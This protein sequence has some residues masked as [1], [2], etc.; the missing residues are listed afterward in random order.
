MNEGVNCHQKRRPLFV[1]PQAA[2]DIAQYQEA[3]VFGPTIGGSDQFCSNLTLTKRPSAHMSSFQTLADKN[4]NKIDKR[5]GQEEDPSEQLVRLTCN[6]RLINGQT[7]NDS[8]ISLPTFQSIEA[9]LQGCHISIMNI[10]NM[11]FAVEFSEKSMH[12]F[13]F[14]YNE[15]ILTHKRLAQGWCSSANIA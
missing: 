11:F 7:L 9:A 15:K 1:P 14:Y 5:L 10:S 8:T 2:R 13:N 12:Y 4:Q 6:L 3:G